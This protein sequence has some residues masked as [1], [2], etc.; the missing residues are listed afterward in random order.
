MKTK[1]GKQIKQFFDNIKQIKI[2]RDV[3]KA[4]LNDIK[5]EI[6]DPKSEFNHLHLSTDEKY[7][8]ITTIISIPE[9]FQLAG[10][11]IMK[12]QKLQELA[13]PINAYINKKLNYGEYFLAPEFYYI[14]NVDDRNEDGE[15]ILEEVSCSYVAEWKYAPVLDNYPN[16]KWE[17]TG[18]IVANT[19]LIGA[20]TTLLII[21]I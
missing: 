8:S 14:D 11:D 1:F 13:R 17:L 16:F 9:S 12:Y 10:S 18:F 15:E 21:L 19:L 3:R 4:F 20:L 2:D 5:Y 6:Q 7:D